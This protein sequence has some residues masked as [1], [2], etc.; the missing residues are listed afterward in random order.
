MSLTL[1]G[2]M[3]VFI[4]LAVLFLLGMPVGFAMGIVGFC[5]FWYVVSFKAAITM[6]GADIWC[7]QL[8][9]C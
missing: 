2:I 8:R 3:G 4:L 5:G 9:Y 6:V 1:V 7:I